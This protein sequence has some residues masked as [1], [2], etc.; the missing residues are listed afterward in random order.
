VG[1]QWTGVWWETLKERE[2]FEDLVID[3]R[4]TKIYR[5]EIDWDGVDWA[6]LTQDRD[7]WWAVVNTVMN[8][9]VP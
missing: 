3:G 4:M 9:L 1:Q 2:C 8:L 7:N 6:D 5:M